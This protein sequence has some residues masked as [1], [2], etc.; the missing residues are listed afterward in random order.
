L[1]QERRATAAGVKVTDLT[2]VCVVSL[3]F[4]AHPLDTFLLHVC[5]V[6]LLRNSVQVHPA[7]I[8]QYYIT[9]QPMADGGTL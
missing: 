4:W 1:E 8:V 5:H 7:F 2:M 9:L 6:A 3:F